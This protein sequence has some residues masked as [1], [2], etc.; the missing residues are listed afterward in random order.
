[1]KKIMFL[2][3]AILLAAILLIMSCGGGNTQ[4]SQLFQL[5]SGKVIKVAG[6]NKMIAQ[7]GDS[8]LILNYQTEIPI[9]DKDN[10][11]KEVNEIWSVFQKD[12]EAA[13]LATGIIRATHLEGS[14]FVRSGRGYGFVFVKNSDG[15]WHLNDSQ[16]NNNPSEQV[17]AGN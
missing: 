1:M 10:L 12:V 17:K 8:A 9:E 7:N 11:N 6:I 15:Q 4:S 2:K 14:G 13:N 16:K 5:P 3:P